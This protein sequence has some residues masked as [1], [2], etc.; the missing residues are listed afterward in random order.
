[1][2]SLLVAVVVR[3][4]EFDYCL[5]AHISI[6]DGL[7]KRLARKSSAWRL[8]IMN[9]S[10]SHGINC[11]SIV[12]TDQCAPKFIYIQNSLLSSKMKV[13]SCLLLSKLDGRISFITRLW[14]K[15]DC[16]WICYRSVEPSR[17]STFRQIQIIAPAGFW[18]RG[19][20]PRRHPRS[21]RVYTYKNK[22]YLLKK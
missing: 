9:H 11:E 14:C 17:Y 21:P 7:A 4:K 5:P 12:F 22:E 2:S 13:Q 16:M 18:P 6:E 15:A 3:W 10:V 8:A 19:Q 20:N 1:M